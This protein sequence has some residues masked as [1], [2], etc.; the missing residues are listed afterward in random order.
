MNLNDSSAVTLVQSSE[1]WKN[2]DKIKPAPVDKETIGEST[3]AVMDIVDST[4]SDVPPILCYSP[5]ET[6]D[7]TELQREDEKTVPYW[8]PPALKEFDGDDRLGLKEY[9]AVLN[10]KLLRE[11]ESL[12]INPSYEEMCQTTRLLPI[13][14]TK[15][16]LLDAINSNQVVVV[17]GETGYFRIILHD[18]SFYDYTGCFV[19]EREVDATPNLHPR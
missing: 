5:T 17:S 15:G 19:R 6:P 13:Y 1:Y 7:K 9:N 4:E 14:E 3:A 10:E 12:R 8:E 2:H 18:T 11:M 16:Q